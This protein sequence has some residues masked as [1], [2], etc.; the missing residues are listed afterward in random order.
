MIPGVYRYDDDKGNTYID[1]A[2]KF[3]RKLAEGDSADD[4]LAEDEK[5]SAEETLVISPQFLLQEDVDANNLPDEVLRWLA[6]AENDGRDSWKGG[7]DGVE[8]G[9]KVSSFAVLDHLLR[10]LKRKI[11]GL[12]EV[13][14]AGNSAGA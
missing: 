4:D 10:D 14:I 13:V 6:D 7:A 2:K 3:A 9:R 8:P 11:P 12:E 5:I 1:I